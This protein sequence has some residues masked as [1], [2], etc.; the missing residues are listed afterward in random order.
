MAEEENQNEEEIN[1]DFEGITNFMTKHKTI[2]VYSVLII[3]LLMT[4]YS[5]TQNIPNLHDDKYQYLLSPDDPYVFLRYATDIANGNLPA[6]D[7]LRYYPDGV[8]ITHENLGSAYLAGYLLK[9]VRIFNPSATMFDI[10][11]YYAPVLLVIGIAAFFF[12][13]KEILEN[14]AA[15]LTASGFLAFSIAIFFRTAAG[16]LEKEPLFLPLMV[17]SFLFFIR[18]YKQKETNKQFYLNGIL[19][20]I[21]TGLAGFSSGLFVFI[22]IYLSIFFIVEV[23]LQKVNK[24]KLITF[25]LWLI[26]MYAL[27]LAVTTKYGDLT[28]FFNIIQFQIPAVALFFGAIA[29]YVKKPAKISWLPSGVFHILVGLG[30]ILLIGGV[31]SIF[32][33]GFLAG[34][35]GFVFE[36]IE[37]P[38]ATDRFTQSVSE[39]QPPTFLGGGSSWWTTFGVSLITPGGG[40]VSIGL[41][42]MLFFLGGIVMFYKEFKNFRY[43]KFITAIFFIF[44]CAVIFEHFS[45]DQ[46]YLWVNAI[47]SS[48]YFYFV[49][50]GI[51]M[52]VFMFFEHSKH[53]HL[54]KI[55]STYLLVLVWFIIATMAANGSVRLFFV[56]AFPAAIMAAYFIK[57]SSELIAEKTNENY[58]ILPYIFGAVIIVMMFWMITISNASMY[59]GL[60][61]YYDA[62]NW[63]KN[64][65]PT[66]AVFTHWW[67]YGYIVQTIGERATVVDPGNF[68]T[69]RNYDTGGYLFNAFSNNDTLAY[70]NTYGR[71]SYWFIISEDIPKFFQIARLGALSNMTG[72]LPENGTLGLESYFSTYAMMNQTT[73]IRPNN[74]GVYPEYPMIIVM[75]PISGPSQVLKDFRVDNTLYSGE[76]TF[77]LRVIIPVT[78]N[79]TGPVLVQVYNSMT[80]KMEVFKAQ[81]M[82]EQKVGCSDVNNTD[83]VPVVPTC[84]LALNGGVLNIPYK[85][86]DVLFTQ[87]YVLGREIPGYELVYNSSTPLDLLAMAGRTTNIQIYK[88]NYTAL[89]QNKGW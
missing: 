51:T 16:F 74:L 30:L 22:E 5:R 60:Q 13:T 67:D 27:L 69:Q 80:Q 19:G 7:T 21:F 81:C 28:N 68:Y 42:F 52:I 40:Y 53:E 11:A 17:F 57:W 44:M 33:P 12:L 48:Q 25:G 32:K 46:R 31:V 62:L 37:S 89:E 70:L 29:V 43:A 64:N 84:I 87:L 75:E 77:I 56:L 83:G 73:G 59:P 65:T 24:Q 39:N 76:S 47:F 88:F 20:G 2:L 50:F 45:A 26:V 54:E 9:F 58:K 14:E 63:A 34:T 49:L 66:N 23:L 79:S 4:F 86:K 82:C 55:N 72:A 41:I 78:N 3:L 15:A 18:A 1:I 61:P 8:D 35:V 6:N 85:T 10:G 71:P 36:R 38:T